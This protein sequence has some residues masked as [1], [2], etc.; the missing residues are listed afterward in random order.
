MITAVVFV[1]C[2]YLGLW[3]WERSQTATGTFQNLGYALQWPFFGLFAIYVWWRTPGL[4]PVSRPSTSAD[5]TVTSPSRPSSPPLPQ[6]VGR[7]I[8][9]AAAS[10]D[11]T[12]DGR[13]LAAYN[14]YLA[15]LNQQETA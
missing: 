5:P 2:L 6:E 10:E 15:R 4:G 13:E 1:A 11:D 14:A 12:E 8:T 9:M 7:R 3:Q